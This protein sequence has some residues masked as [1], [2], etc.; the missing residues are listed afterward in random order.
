MNR[1][2][3]A[4]QFPLLADYYERAAALPAFAE[5]T[6]PLREAVAGWGEVR[7]PGAPAAPG[8]I[9]NAAQREEEAA[10]KFLGPAVFI[11]KTRLTKAVTP[12]QDDMERSLVYPDQ[13]VEIV[14][15][16]KLKNGAWPGQAGSGIDATIKLPDGSIGKVPAEE[17]QRL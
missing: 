5:T 16:D 9:I 14:G 8:S 3:D 6:Y 1:E 7:G 11:G 17:L 4:A 10:T 2:V 13:R 15:Y 12:V